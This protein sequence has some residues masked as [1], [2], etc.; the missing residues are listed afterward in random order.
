M[1]VEGALTAFL[2]VVPVP[3]LHARVAGDDTASL[4]VLRR[5]GSRI[6]GTEVSHVGRP[7]QPPPAQRTGTA[8]VSP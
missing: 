6:V 2:D 8:R 4:T 5:A 3:P 1:T 7:G